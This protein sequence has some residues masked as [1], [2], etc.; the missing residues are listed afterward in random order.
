MEQIDKNTVLLV[1][2][3]RRKSWKS[4][5]FRRHLTVLRARPNHFPYPRTS[6]TPTASDLRQRRVSPAQPWRHLA[7]AV[8]PRDAQH[9]LHQ[10]Y[11]CGSL[12]TPGSGTHVRDRQ[13]PGA[14]Q[15]ISRRV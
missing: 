14:E 10:H 12:Q 3:N 15:A 11:D 5:S 9:S 2:S 1:I 4:M 8:R 6:S 7:A 13:L